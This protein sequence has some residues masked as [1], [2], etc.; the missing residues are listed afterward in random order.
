MS[1]QWKSSF[2]SQDPQID[3][4]HQALFKL[5]DRL[6]THR[7]ESDIE[8]LNGLLDQ[9]LEHTFSHFFRE[10]AAM[11]VQGYP[12]LARH[13]EQHEVMRKALIE[14]LRTVTKGQ[15]AL[16]TFI[17]HL[18]DSFIYHF[19][20]DDMT[21]VTWQKAQQTPAKGN[22]LPIQAGRHP[23]PGPVPTYSLGPGC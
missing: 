4:D 3:E 20:T 19:E 9:L 7:R 23:R 12:K 22:D 18:K 1:R 17:Q 2:C 11:R 6:A 15:L 16:P 8:D 5:L 14:S 13:A 21:F 10:E